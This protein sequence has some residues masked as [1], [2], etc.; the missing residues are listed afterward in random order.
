MPIIPIIFPSFRQSKVYN[1]IF[2]VGYTGAGEREQ[3]GGGA[4]DAA[5]YIFRG[6]TFKSCHGWRVK[7]LDLHLLGGQN[8]IFEN[9]HS[10][11]SVMSSPMTSRFM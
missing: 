4:G 7:V 5:L 6:H 10:R 2:S 1:S 3:E 9:Q 8:F 11:I